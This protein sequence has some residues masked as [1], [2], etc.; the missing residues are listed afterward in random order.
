M[1]L[2]EK[3]FQQVLNHLP[4]TGMETL[5]IWKL[6]RLR[7]SV[8]NHLPLTGMETIVG[9]EGNENGISI[10][11]KSLTPHGDGNFRRSFGLIGPKCFKSLT[12]HGDGNIAFRMEMYV[13]VLCFKSLPPH[14]NGNYVMMFM[15]GITIHEL[16]LNHLPLTGMEKMR[17]LSDTIAFNNSDE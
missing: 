17:R 9:L 7:S 4:L 14:G 2:L 16:V 15:I 8:L 5:G 13:S 11:F 3:V 12:P 10:S 1:H 6:K